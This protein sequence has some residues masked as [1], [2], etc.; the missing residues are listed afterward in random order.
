MT[1][2]QVR[3]HV[4]ARL[5]DYGTGAGLLA[6]SGWLQRFRTASAATDRRHADHLRRIML[7]IGESNAPRC[8]LSHRGRVAC[9]ATSGPSAM[10]PRPAPWCSSAASARRRGLFACHAGDS[11]DER[12]HVLRF[13]QVGPEWAMAMPT[14]GRERQT[15]VGDVVR[16]R[17]PSLLNVELTAPSRTQQRLRTC[18][19][20]RHL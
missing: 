4:A 15:G 6:S 9:A 11:A 1:D 14:T 7:A 3:N 16:H 2:A 17:T 8:S 13:P 12:H 20:L 5:G 18:F 19:G 10:K